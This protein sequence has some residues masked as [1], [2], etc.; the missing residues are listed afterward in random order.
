MDI[1]N[2]NDLTRELARRARKTAK[3]R[4]VAANRLSTSH[5]YSEWSVTLASIVLIVIPLMDLAGIGTPKDPRA[6]RA[7]EV[8]L[9]V[10]VLA[11]SLLLAHESYGLRS[12]RMHQCGIELNTLADEASLMAN[13]VTS[14]QCLALVNRYQYILEKAENHSLSDYIYY[15][16]NESE[17]NSMALRV[18]AWFRYSVSRGVSLLH[19]I[20]LVALL[21]WALKWQL[22]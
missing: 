20:G 14:E 6:V 10:A 8:T 15:K 3:I 2:P 13:V 11:F 22:F 7:V 1:A 18:V 9:A 19:Y 17:Y 12:E 4:F 21:V 5:R 16:L